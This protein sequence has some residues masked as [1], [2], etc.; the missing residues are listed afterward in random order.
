MAD[1]IEQAYEQMEKEEQ[2]LDSRAKQQFGEDSKQMPSA[3]TVSPD[4]LLDVDSMPAT[5]TSTSTSS[6]QFKAGGVIEGAEKGAAAGA[7]GGAVGGD[8]RK[9]AK[10]GA[11]TGA[12][13]GGV[14][15]HR[16]NKQQD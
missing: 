8:I 7:V 10:I 15:Q 4:Q 1:S 12:V 2:E 6:Q 11:E 3:L 13:V 9:G 14:R 5:Q 16:D